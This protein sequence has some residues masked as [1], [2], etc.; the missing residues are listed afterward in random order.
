MLD[1]S[2][3]APSVERLAIP[4]LLEGLRQ[5]HDRFGV[6]AGITAAPEDAAVAQRTEE[7]RDDVRRYLGKVIAWAEDGEKE[8]ATADRLLQP[9]ADWEPTATAAASAGAAPAAPESAA[10]TVEATAAV[11]AA[12]FAP[13]VPLPTP[14]ATTDLDTPFTVD[15]A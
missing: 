13:A 3:V 4:D 1:G 9:W 2:A 7:L 10:S 11:P 5:A 8:R 15:G 12:S 14:P 6:E